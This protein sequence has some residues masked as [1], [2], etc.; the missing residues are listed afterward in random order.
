M[1]YCFKPEGVNER[2][3]VLFWFERQRKHGLVELDETLEV[4]V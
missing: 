3:K 4:D 1:F 2:W